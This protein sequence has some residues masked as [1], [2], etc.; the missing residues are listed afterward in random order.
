MVVPRPRDHLLAEAL[1]RETEAIGQRYVPDR[2]TDFDVE[3]GWRVT[4][5]MGRGG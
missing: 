2:H 5:E 4:L 3:H 1:T